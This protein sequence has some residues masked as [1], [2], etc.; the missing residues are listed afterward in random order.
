MKITINKSL[1]FRL[2][3]ALKAGQ[4]DTFSIPELFY[5]EEHLKRFE[6]LCKIETIKKE[7]ENE[8]RTNTR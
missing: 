4:I 6:E 5:P 2:L 7:K 1:R 3:L 8:N